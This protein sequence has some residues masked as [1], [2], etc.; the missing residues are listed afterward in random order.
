MTYQRL[1]SGKDIDML[2]TCAAIMQSAIKYKDLLANE[3]PG[4]RG[5]HFQNVSARIET[6][7]QQYFELR[8]KTD[9]P[10][11]EGNELLQQAIYDLTVF[12][13][14]LIEDF[15]KEKVRREGLLKDLGFKEYY[16]K[17]KAGDPEAIKSLVEHFRAH[18]NE[19]MK[20]EFIA[21][22]IHPELIS[23]IFGYI[24]KFK[25]FKPEKDAA[26]ESRKTITLESVKVLNEI[27]DEVISISKIARIILG[28]DRIK[29]SEFSF[30]KVKNSIL[31]KRT[32]TEM[33]TL[34]EEEEL[35]EV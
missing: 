31:Q 17:V 30:L 21:K 13:V 12:R 20:A 27:Y 25:D 35:A 33:I 29:K 3:R 10:A 8:S 7:R 14:Q 32:A 19:V 23:R 28:D 22:G 1:Y 26:R 5:H 6:I 16:S 18:V 34:I 11:G 4:W 9:L 2:D 24:N 15:K